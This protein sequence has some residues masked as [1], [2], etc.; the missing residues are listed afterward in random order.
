MKI[1]IK[2]EFDFDVDEVIGDMIGNCYLNEIE[3]DDELRSM[4]REYTNEY[5]R[6]NDYGMSFLA[7]SGS[8]FQQDDFEDMVFNRVKEMSK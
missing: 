5:I 3:D 4:I 2:D 6:N 1:V 8:S 7:E